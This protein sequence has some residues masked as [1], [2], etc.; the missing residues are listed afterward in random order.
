MRS[1]LVELP[2]PFVNL[3]LLPSELSIIVKEVVTL[4]A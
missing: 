2:R 4:S 3:Y 1:A